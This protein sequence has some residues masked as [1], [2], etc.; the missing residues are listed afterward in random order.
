M[1]TPGHLTCVAFGE[2]ISPFL[3]YIKII[4]YPHRLL[5]WL[6]LL[7][8]LMCAKVVS[9]YVYHVVGFVKRFLKY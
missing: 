8:A 5:L 7:E 1:H 4:L 3:F 6:L 9:F 2:N